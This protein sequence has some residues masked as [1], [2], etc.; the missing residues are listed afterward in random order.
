[1]RP[2][3]DE[4]FM[5]ITREVAKRSTCLSTIAA[6]VI[7][8]DK[9][10]ISTGYNG[11]PRKTMDCIERGNCL[12]RELKIPSG[13]RYELCRSVHAEMNAIINA[14]RTGEHIVDSDLYLWGMKV[15]NNE[16]KLV[17]IFPCFICKKMIINAGIRRVIASNADGTFNVY[18][19]EEWSKDWQKKDMLDDMKVFDSKYY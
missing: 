7:V 4:Y 3:W 15:Y 14:G 11:A 13:H 17:D 8:K 9:K 19:V 10:I 5:N 2:D 16:N 12:R 6:A 18:N 1:M